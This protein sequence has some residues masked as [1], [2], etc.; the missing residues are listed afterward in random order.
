ML[1]FF[2]PAKNS[3]LGLCFSYLQKYQIN[4]YMV[5]FKCIFV[6]F[7]FAT[8]FKKGSIRKL[9]DRNQPAGQIGQE[10]NGNESTPAECRKPQPLPLF[11]S[12]RF[13]GM[14]FP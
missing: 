6:N 3:M 8:E 11:F 2:F 4:S 1:C 5:N 14:L 9:S 10:K 7:S 12:K 13:H